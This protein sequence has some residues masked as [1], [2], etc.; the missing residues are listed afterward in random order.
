MGEPIE[1]GARATNTFDQGQIESSGKNSSSY[2]VTLTAVLS[3][4][5]TLITHVCTL[6]KHDI[7]RTVTQTSKPPKTAG[8]RNSLLIQRHEALY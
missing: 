2:W 4:L 3:K 6:N 1:G 7:V 8:I 5:H